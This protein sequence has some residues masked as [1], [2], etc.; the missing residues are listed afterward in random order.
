MHAPAL[1][2]TAYSAS[3]MW[4]ANAATVSPSADTADGRL[5]LTVAN[6][7]TMLHRSLE[8]G[9]TYKRLSRIF[10]DGEAFAVHEAL[11]AHPDFSDEGAANHVRLCGEHGGAGVELFVY[12]RRRP[13]ARR[14]FR[15]ANRFW[16]R[17]RSRARMDLTGE[18]AS[19][20]P[21]SPRLRSTQARFT[22]TSSASER[23]IRFS[24]TRRPLPT[25]MRPSMRSGKPRKGA[26]L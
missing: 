17:R 3:S 12:G 24:T 6:L 8:H 18:P 20:M 22:M 16:H 1:L 26:S 14:A 2:K 13:R 11:P 4:A 25:R 9:Q 23:W 15:R 21:V 7:S 5:H 19:F 10:A